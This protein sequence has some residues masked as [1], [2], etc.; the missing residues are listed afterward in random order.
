MIL[1]IY[2]RLAERH[3]SGEEPDEAIGLGT[4]DA[5]VR[6]R[7]GSWRGLWAYAARF[8][9]IGAIITVLLGMTGLWLS[10]TIRKKP[11]DTLE[12]AQDSGGRA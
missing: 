5:V 3:R 6:E 1:E 4:A 7:F 9:A 11:P 12:T 8:D 2:H 10:R